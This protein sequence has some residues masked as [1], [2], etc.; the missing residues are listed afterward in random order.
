MTTKILILTLAIGLLTACSTDDAD[1]QQSEEGRQE[2]I[3]LKT[4]VRQVME[5]TRAA[6]FDDDAA[7]QREAQFTCVAYQANTTTVYI[8]STTVD[9]TSS[10]QWAFNNGTDHY[11][12][13]ET[14]NLDFFGYMPVSH[15]NISSI[16]YTAAHNVTFTCSGLPMTNTG[17]DSSLKEFMFG[18]ALAQNSGNA[19]S[20]VPLTFQH[21]FARIKLQLS[22]S[23]PDITINSIT[24][25]SIYNNGSYDH[26]AST[27]WTTSGTATD[28]VLTLT[29]TARI[30]NSKPSSPQ[31]QIG[32]YYIMIPQDWAGD[33]EVNADCQFWGET[34]N[35]PNLTTTVPTTWQPG[36]S[37]TYTFTISPDD[38]KV[39]ITKFTEQW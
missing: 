6:T 28:F 30:F 17:Q 36:Y 10:D 32:E 4:D 20:G 34:K 12:W 38:L 37:Y 1:S 29:G 18:M 9:W 39:D 22:A 24:F 13:P 3:L 21:P 14:G 33:I 26:N 8:P 16:A 35:Y 25:K 23:H 11:Y 7:L 31:Q 19:S 15:S 2:E 27:K 5:G